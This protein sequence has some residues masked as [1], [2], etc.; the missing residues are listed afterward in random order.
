MGIDLR[1]F[2]FR[3]TNRGEVTKDGVSV[4]VCV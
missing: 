2:Y 4:G 1:N 3:D